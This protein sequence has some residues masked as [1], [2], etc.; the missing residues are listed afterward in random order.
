MQASQARLLFGKATI[1]LAFLMLSAGAACASD[2]TSEQRQ[3]RSDSDCALIGIGCQCVTCDPKFDAVN[4]KFVPQLK[5]LAACSTAETQRCAESG[6][7]PEITKPHA[8][9]QQGQCAVVTV[10]VQH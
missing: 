5:Y 9:C 3:C 10:P 8:V 6:A 1:A 4:T 2:I 7:C